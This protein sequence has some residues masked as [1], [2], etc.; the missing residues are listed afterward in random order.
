MTEQNA[1]QVLSWP[2][3]GKGNDGNEWL[4]FRCPTPGCKSEGVA[5]S[6]EFAFGRCGRCGAEM[7]IVSTPTTTSPT[8]PKQ[9]APINLV[10]KV[11]AAATIAESEV[12]K[13]ELATAQKFAE[14]L[15]RLV[16][17]R[18]QCPDDDR[19]I[20]LMAYWALLFDLQRSVLDLIPKHL[21]GGAFA[22]VR[23][24]MEAVARAHVAVKGTASDIES[25][26]NDTYRTN[27]FTI[28]PWIDS[29]FGAG[30]SFTKTF[31]RA[32]SALHSYTHAGISQLARRYDD[33]NLRP[34][35]RDG[36]I[37]EVIRVCTSAV[38]MVTNLV[39]KHL[40]WTEEAKKAGE[41]FE[42]WGKHEDPPSG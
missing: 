8:A 31:D 41:L 33:H 32:R 25:L 35:Y 9:V 3:S 42:K 21:C 7:Q 16:V 28:G 38:W 37:V 15:E 40:G 13:K 22:L 30:D 19:N 17:N 1:Y 2:H 29:T 24:C 10:P 27:F 34:S 18:G 20:L 14:E 6:G 39:T 36:E 4:A 26:Q 12:V 23:P 11:K 5:R